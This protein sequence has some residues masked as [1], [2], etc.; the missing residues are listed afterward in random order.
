WEEGEFARRLTLAL[1]QQPCGLAWLVPA[2][3]ARSPAV[4]ELREMLAARGTPLLL[5]AEV[6]T[7]AEVPAEGVDFLVCPAGML[8]GLGGVALPK[9]VG[10]EPTA[11]APGLVL[12]T[13]T[14]GRHG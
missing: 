10:G 7:P 12:G 2:G 3:Q 6:N 13:L 8:A 11:G 5:G 9:L 14:G 1:A 4:R